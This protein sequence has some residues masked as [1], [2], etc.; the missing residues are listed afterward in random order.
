VSYET[1][2]YDVSDHVATL[3]LNRPEVMNA[4]NQRMCEEVQDVWMRA[5][6]DDDVRVVVVQANG[7]RA[8]SVGVDRKNRE[9][10]S[11]SGTGYS[12]PDNPFAR[13]GP[14]HYLGPKTNQL[15]KPVISACNG[16]VAGGAAYF[17]NESDIVICSE[18]ATFFDP[19]LN[20]GMVS[21][22]E[23]IGM[24]RKVPVGEALRLVLMGLDERMSA[25]RALQ[26]GLVSEVVPTEELRNRARDLA[27]K[28]AK[29]PPIAVQGTIKALWAELD[30]L[31]NRVANAGPNY[32]AIGNPV[33]HADPD[34]LKFGAPRPKWELR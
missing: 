26:I 19:H 20:Y 8:F 34:A 9:E 21:V 7:G 1:V 18:D 16:M 2:L 13:I 33:G 32:S 12:Q 11:S 31:S 27:L 6:L 30:L 28:I 14:D 22:L 5:R 15:W 25:T 17:T 24:A 4:F 23:N 3:T 10:G 29:K